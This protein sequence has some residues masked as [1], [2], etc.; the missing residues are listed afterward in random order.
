MH[1]GVL[2]IV[3]SSN[4][5]DNSTMLA[6]D[7]W[8]STLEECVAICLQGDS[9]YVCA[10]R[11]L[12]HILRVLVGNKH[13]VLTPV[14]H[15]CIL[16]RHALLLHWAELWTVGCVFIGVDWWPHTMMCMQQLPCHCTYKV[17]HNVV[18]VA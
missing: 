5:L 11:G 18:D 8:L 10:L 17:M 12:F 4:W 7:V 9:S 2:P 15:P 1:S 13:T 3:A 14:Y 16:M 6:A